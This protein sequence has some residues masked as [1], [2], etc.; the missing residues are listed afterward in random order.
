MDA[1]AHAVVLYRRAGLRGSALGCAARAESLAAEGGGVR[2]PALVAAGSELPVTDREREVIALLGL[3]LSNRDI[4]E[5]L[6]LSTRT[7]EGHI[8]KAMTK[9]GAASRE[10]LASLLKP[11]KRTDN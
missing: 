3:G 2:T 4:A 1:A 7:V 10:E 11:G 9:T 6:V 5:R 8:Y